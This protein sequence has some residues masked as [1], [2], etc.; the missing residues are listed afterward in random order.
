[1]SFSFAFVSLRPLRLRGSGS[2]GERTISAPSNHGRIA[3]TVYAP[4]GVAATSQQAATSAAV[5]VLEYGGN[6]ID[7]ATAVPVLAVVTDDDRPAVICSRSSGAR[8]QETRRAQRERP[9]GSLM[10]REEL[11]KR[12][13]HAV[14]RRRDGHGA[15]RRRLGC[16]PRA[17]TITPST[18]VQ[19]AIGYAEN[20]SS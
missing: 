12:D 14:E 9:A 18:A 20:D 10:T 5:E 13:A 1:M 19:P 8:R 16:A 3:S 7:A 2:P 15:G 6:A 4:N 17:G 11:V